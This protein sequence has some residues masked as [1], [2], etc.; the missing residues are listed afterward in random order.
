MKIVKILDSSQINYVNNLI[1]EIEFHDGKKSAEGLAKKVKLNKQALAE[2]DKYEELMSYINDIFRKNLWLKQRYLPKK[3]SQA[4]I[5][6]YE[7]GDCYGRHFDNSH[8]ST[9]LGSIRRDWSFTLMLSSNSDYEG[10]ELKIETGS[11]T[12]EVKLDAGDL[13]IYPSSYIHSVL[14]ITKGKRLAYV[15]WIASHIKDQ[16][17]FETINAYEDMHLA[18]SKY[19]LSEE[20]ELSLGYVQNKLQLLISN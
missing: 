8:I 10:G 15:G 12:H 20:D 9:G 16:L 4:V 6:K 19:N 2:G 18:L 14:N 7:V 3:F 5:N 13:V 17:G 11:V 1:G